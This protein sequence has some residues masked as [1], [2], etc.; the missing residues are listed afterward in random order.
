MPEHKGQK[1]CKS[2][3]S[4][5]VIMHRETFAMCYYNP[6]PF[7]PSKKQTLKLNFFYNFLKWQNF[8]IFIKA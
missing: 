6:P 2:L 1:L 5:C 7:P 3:C 4:F 8:Y